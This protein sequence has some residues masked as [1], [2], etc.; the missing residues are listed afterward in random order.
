MIERAVVVATT[1]ARAFDLWVS[2]VD[3]WW[4][5][6]HRVS[7]EAGGTL[8]IEPGVDGRFFER[9][10]DGRELDYGRVVAW[11]PPTLLA[12]DFFLGGGRDA[13]TRVEVRF[14]AAGAGTRVEVRHLPG[15][16][17]PDRFDATAPR[18]RASWDHVTAAFVAH[19][20]TIT[21][22]TR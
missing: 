17:P 21:E 14:V 19:A 2:R 6:G 18:Y 4:P 22:T 20:R 5:P 3:L 15:A 16:L 12:Y 9:T 1:P 13:P 8:R 7:G 10:P 11:Q